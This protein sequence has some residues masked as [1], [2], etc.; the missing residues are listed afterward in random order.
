MVVLE[1]SSDT[2]FIVELLVD[3]ILLDVSAFDDAHADFVASGKRVEQ[4]RPNA[5]P[6]ERGPRTVRDR[7]AGTATGRAYIEQCGMVGRNC[8]CT[9]LAWLSMVTPSNS[10]TLRSREQDPVMVD[11]W[12]NSSMRTFERQGM[13]GIG[14]RADEIED[15]PTIDLIRGLI[16]VVRGLRRSLLGTLVDDGI[17]ILRC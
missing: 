5:Q 11:E 6:D 13:F 17:Q 16:V 8:T 4:L 7:L 3:L 15:F 2:F 1:S 9:V 12:K 14:D 10:T